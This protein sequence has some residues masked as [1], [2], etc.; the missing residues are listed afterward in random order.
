MALKG[1]PPELTRDE[2]TLRRF[3]RELNAT[4]A[5]LVEQGRWIEAMEKMEEAKRLDPHHR[6]PVP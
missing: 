5:T 6:D 3:Q 1:L 4:G 2:V